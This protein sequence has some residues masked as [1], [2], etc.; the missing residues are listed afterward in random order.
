MYRST[1]SVVCTQQTITWRKVRDKYILCKDGVYFALTDTQV[2]ELGECLEEIKNVQS[3]SIV[4][5]G[6][7]TDSTTH[8]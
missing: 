1:Y 8:K 4:E 2:V 3:N 6:W 5:R 7:Q